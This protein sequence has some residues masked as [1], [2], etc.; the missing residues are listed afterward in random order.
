M[1]LVV[2]SGGGY[3]FQNY[4]ID[5]LSQL[6]L[7]WRSEDH[8]TT[9][10]QTVSSVKQGGKTIRVASFNIEAFNAEKASNLRVMTVLAE[11]IRRFDVVA[12][13]GICSVDQSVLS[14]LV[15]LVNGS[16]HRYDFLVGQR[17]GHNN[18]NE[19][20]AFVYDTE[21][22]DT[23]PR[24]SYSVHDPSNLLHRPPLVGVF[25]VR[26]LPADR[27]FTFTLINVH[28]DPNL[29]QEE[30]ETL[31]TVYR[32]VRR[33]GRGEDDIILLGDLNTDYEHLEKLG[34][35][36]DL[37]PVNTKLPTNTRG[38]KQYDNILCHQRSTS[39]YTGR[40]GVLD[41]IREF[42]LT[43]EDALE[44]SNHLP[45]WAEFTVYEHGSH[46][47]LAVRYKDPPS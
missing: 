24:A 11:V 7:I 44:I 31:I 28:T 5:G 18:S 42:N 30:L 23:D 35:I 34:Q 43:M 10:L 22:I 3:F 37:R 27:A 40:C 16:G 32:A 14:E 26:G 46:G 4:Q 9:S 13:Q 20:Y 33:D 12:I 6:R 17:H 21:H 29:V 45:V 41:F 8:S 47:P 19:Q 39:E 15:G 2:F 36:A 38:T 25:R 1:L